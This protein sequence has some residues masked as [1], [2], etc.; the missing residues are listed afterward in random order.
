MFSCL[1]RKTG[2]FNLPHSNKPTSTESSTVRKNRE[3]VT[4]VNA[5]NGDAK[6]EIIQPQIQNTAIVTYN[7]TKAPSLMEVDNE[8]KQ[9][10]I[11][12]TAVAAEPEPKQVSSMEVNNEEK[13]EK[14]D[15]EVE[16]EEIANVKRRSGLAGHAKNTETHD[17]NSLQI[18]KHPKEQRYVRML[19]NVRRCINNVFKIFSD[20]TLIEEAL[21]KNDFLRNLLEGQRLQA[22]IEAMYSRDIKVGE[23]IIREGTVGTQ[24][25][26]SAS[27]T[28]EITIKDVFIS[29]FNDSRVFGELAI[30]YDAKRQATIK[31][32]SS[33]KV[34]VLEQDV[35]QQLMLRSEIE[36]HDQL[37]NFL[38]NVP[39]LNTVSDQILGRVTDL[40]KK[41]FFETGSIIVRQGDKGDKF[42]IISAGSVTITK[43]GEGEVSITFI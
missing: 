33:G 5:A 11:Q 27:G 36:H 1:C 2:S 22:V 30:L 38:K 42:Y 3:S 6:S 16:E 39:K 40:L 17:V 34:W 43:D 7:E 14:Q 35:Y 8:E 19:L 24:M 20:E 9:E 37:L 28:Y 21:N 32:L 4:I 13:K 10:K 31:A 12:N 41:E 26:I 23:V 29:K 25:Y 18:V 15:E